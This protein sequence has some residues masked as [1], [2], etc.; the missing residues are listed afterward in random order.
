MDD[1]PAQ[2]I[3]VLPTI[4]DQLGL[5]T[6]WR[7]DGRSLRDGRGRPARRV[8]VVSGD[9]V[10]QPFA[11]VPAHAGRG[12]RR[13]ARPVRGGRRRRGAVR[14]GRGLRAGRAGARPTCPRRP[15]GRRAGRARA[16]SPLLAD[17]DPDAALL[18]ALATGRISGEMKPGTDLAFALNGTDPGGRAHVQRRG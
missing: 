15:A 18:P 6:G 3:D 5:R 11:D 14:R 17:V 12:G 4:A 1:S 9:G 13:A 16:T 2:T 10:P 8:A 7:F